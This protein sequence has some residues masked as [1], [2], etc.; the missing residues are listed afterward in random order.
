MSTQVEGEHLVVTVEDDGPGVDWEALRAKASELGVAASALDRTE[1]VIF[2][3]GVSSKTSVTELSG[4]GVG[5]GAVRDACA[6]LGGTVKIESRHGLGTRV[7]FVL[8]KDQSVYEGHA[9]ML[10]RPRRTVTV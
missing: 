6:A 5:M 7:S 10:R 1:N 4:R 8:P 9:A 2:L 3:P